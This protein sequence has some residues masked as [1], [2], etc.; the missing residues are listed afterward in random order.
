MSTRHVI[1]EAPAFGHRVVADVVE[2]QIITL[3]TFGEIFLSVIDDVIGAQLFRHLQVARAAHSCDLGVE[4]LR[5]LEREGSNAA[6]CTI[7]QDF[8]PWMNLSCP[9]ALQRS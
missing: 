9:E 5:N 2:N 8:L 3:R 7:D 4:C 6:R 1:K